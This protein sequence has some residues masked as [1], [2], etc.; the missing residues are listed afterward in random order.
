MAQDCEQIEDESDEVR[1]SL[2]AEAGLND[3][4]AFPFVYAAIYL[5]TLGGVQQWGLKWVAWEVVGR[6]VI[7]V[8]VG[9]A[10][11]WLLA[12]IAFRAPTSVRASELGDPLFVVVVPFVAYAAG[13]LAHGW[14]FLSVFVCAMTLR[15]ADRG[16][17][18]HDS[19]H[20]VIERLERLFTL[21]VLLLLGAALTNGLLGSL[22]WGAVG[23]GLLLVFVIRPVVAWIALG[24]SRSPDHVLDGQLGPRERIVAAFFGVR[25][26]GSIYYI[27]YATSKHSF[28]QERLLWSALAFT[29]VLSVVVHGLTATP[30]MRWLERVR[31][32]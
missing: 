25:G 6:T 14:G 27:A 30:A 15:H 29:I 10:V 18:Y 20:G 13:E 2:T 4:L 8:V 31:P 21:V 12:K 24:R 5:A 26:V 17:D 23:F 1:F 9:M 11:G 7:G 16:H 3:G 19:M 32:S 22:T 28:P